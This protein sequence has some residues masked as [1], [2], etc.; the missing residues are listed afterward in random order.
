VIREATAVLLAQGTSFSPS[1]AAGRLG[2]VFAEA[3]EPGALGIRGK[4]AGKPTP[5]GAA[6]IVVDLSSDWE[7]ELLSSDILLKKHL[8]KVLSECGATEIVLYLNFGFTEQCNLELHPDSIRALAGLNIGVGVSAYL[9]ED[10]KKISDP[11]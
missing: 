5:Y 2:V 8:T 4:F 10:Q 1:R 7:K 6:S 3:N 11:G 9:I